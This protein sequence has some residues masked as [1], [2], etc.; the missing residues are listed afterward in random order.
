M[1]CTFIFYFFIL[2]LFD[3]IPQSFVDRV[4][5]NAVLMIKSNVV[6]FFSIEVVLSKVLMKHILRAHL[7]M[8]LRN[9]SNIFNI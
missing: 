7:T 8:I 2:P 6:L 4:F 9:G 3:F 1:H 5:N